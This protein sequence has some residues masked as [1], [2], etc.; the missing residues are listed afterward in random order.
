MQDLISSTTEVTHSIKQR[1]ILDL[2]L[3]YSQL[4]SDKKSFCN[5]FDTH[6][7]TVLI[8]YFDEVFY[9]YCSVVCVTNKCVFY[10]TIQKFCFHH[11]K[12]MRVQLPTYHPVCSFF[13]IFPA[14]SQNLLS[15]RYLMSLIQHPVSLSNSLTLV[16][17]LDVASDRAARENHVKGVYFLAEIS[18]P[19]ARMI[20]HPTFSN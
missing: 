2:L 10:F 11:P 14:S 1:N 13:S 12:F 18:Y 7:T 17:L 6:D 19:P 16:K 5:N 15:V 9:K 3:V 20:C 4:A 8:L